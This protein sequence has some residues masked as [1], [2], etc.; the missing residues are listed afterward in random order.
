MRGLNLVDDHRDA[1][2]A[3]SRCRLGDS[4]SLRQFAIPA[5]RVTAI[6]MDKGDNTNK[7]IEMPV[8]Y[9]DM[10]QWPSSAVAEPGIDGD[11]GSDL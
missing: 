8:A 9:S 10:A 11:S 6:G 3:A 1:E 7:K 2:T 5:Q 4:V